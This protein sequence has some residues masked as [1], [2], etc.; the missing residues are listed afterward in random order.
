MILAPK[1]SDKVISKLF[2]EKVVD[3]GPADIHGK[4]ISVPI[5][6]CMLCIYQKQP[7]CEKVRPLGST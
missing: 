5:S 2:I 7:G 6:T 1:Y 4:N 3:D